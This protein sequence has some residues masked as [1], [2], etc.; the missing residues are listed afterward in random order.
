VTRRIVVDPAEDG[1]AEAFVETRRLKAERVEPGAE[2]AA[3]DRLSLGAPH[4]LAPDSRAALRLRHEQQF[5][6]EPTLR[7]AAPE[8]AHDVSL[9][10]RAEKHRERTEI[11]PAATLIVE[12]AEP[13][14]DGLARVRI[15]RIGENEF[16]LH[17]R[18]F[19]LALNI[20]ASRAF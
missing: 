2:A 3:L 4:Q 20:A 19:P 18:S 9:L 5:D 8:S 11:R 15:S 13:A 14:Q 10:A 7:R 1:I 6:E 17:R 12:T 16:G